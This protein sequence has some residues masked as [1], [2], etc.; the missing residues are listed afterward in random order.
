[1]NILVWEVFNNRRV[2]KGYK[3]HHKDDKPWNNK[4]ENLMEVTCSDNM[5]ASA[6]SGKNKSCK[7]VRRLAHDGSYRDFVSYS[8]AAKETDKAGQP[9]IGACVNGK[10]KT[11]GKCKCG[12][13]F[14]WIGLDENDNPVINTKNSYIKSRIIN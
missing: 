5:R 12:K 6:N 14:K 7:K 11:C 2:R 1:M 13:R 10:Q 4:I 9:H 8:E 3:I